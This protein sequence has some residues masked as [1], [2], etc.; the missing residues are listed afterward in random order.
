MIPQYLVEITAWNGSA[1]ETL[2]FST[3]GYMSLPTDTPAN[4]YYAPRIKSP[5]LYSAAMFA[6]GKTWGAGECSFGEIVLTNADGGLD[7]LINY[8]FDGRS[9]VIKQLLATGAII[10]LAACTGGEQPPFT[11][12]E[13]SIRLRDPQASLNVAVQPVKYLGNNSLPDGV[14][15]DA[16]LKGKPKPVLLGKCLNITPS[17]G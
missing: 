9:I 14:E 4:T 10:V 1:L 8:G 15:G 3:L 13:V 6:Q 16:N 2:Y 12:K 5:G 17:H 7:Y 11:T